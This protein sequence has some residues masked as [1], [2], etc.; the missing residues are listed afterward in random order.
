M[1]AKLTLF[2]LLG[3][4]AFAPAAHAQ[5]S[6]PLTNTSDPRFGVG[7]YGTLSSPNAPLGVGGV[8]L[9]YDLRRFRVATFFSLL[10][11][12][13][14]ADGVAVGG[15]FLFALHRA[16]RA[17]F[18]LGVGTALGHVFN[19][20]PAP[21]L[22]YVVVEGLGQI[23]VFLV[24]NVALTGTLGLAFAAGEGRLLFGIGGQL[25]GSFGLTYFF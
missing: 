2:M 20:G 8:S 25:T 12:D 18:S 10:V 11:D 21:D 17:D 3:A 1:Q 5:D 4:L 22:T 13:G 23:R 6:D 7:M 19:P 14:G 9:V 16:R 15:R 24:D